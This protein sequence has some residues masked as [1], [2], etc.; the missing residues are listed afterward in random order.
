MAR[1]ASMGMR[2]ARTDDNEES[3]CKIIT[4]ANEEFNKELNVWIDGEVDNQCYVVTHKPTRLFTKI[5][6]P[7]TNKNLV[8]CEYAGKSI[9]KSQ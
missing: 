4:R 6:A 3:E 9:Y 7:C 5:A 1:C 2:L 8:Y